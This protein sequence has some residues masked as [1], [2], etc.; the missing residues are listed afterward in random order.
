MEDLCF[1]F[2]GDGARE[3]RLAGARRPV[4]QYPLGRIDA[5]PLEQLG[6][7]QRQLDHLADLVDRGAEPADVV[8]GDVGAARLLGLLIFGPQLDLGLLGD[9]DGSLGRGRHDDEADLLEAVGWRIHQLTQ[10]RR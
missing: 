1:G 4:K 9:D 3:A 5:E 7:A 6:M 8:V 2:V 10:L